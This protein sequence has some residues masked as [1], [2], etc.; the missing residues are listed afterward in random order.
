MESS[1]SD[2]RISQELPIL[3]K[4]RYG[5]TAFKTCWFCFF[6]FGIV[7]HAR[8]FSHGNI[9]IVLDVFHNYF[10][11]VRRMGEYRIAYKAYAQM[12]HLYVSN[13]VSTKDI[14]MKE[15]GGELEKT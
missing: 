7:L 4:H 9:S 5:A 10:D 8:Y 1:P 13:S 14:P 11:V 15:L 3:F 6:A 2:V 12:L